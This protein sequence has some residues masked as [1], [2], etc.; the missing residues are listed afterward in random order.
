MLKKPPKNHKIAFFSVR[1]SSK[2]RVTKTLI[3]AAVTGLN[4]PDNEVG[5]FFI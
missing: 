5:R 2:V 3:F 4:F 1:D